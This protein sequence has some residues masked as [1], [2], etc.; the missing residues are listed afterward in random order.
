MFDCLSNFPNLPLVR[1]EAIHMSWSVTSSSGNK[2]PCQVLV[3]YTY[4]YITVLNINT[5]FTK[6][7]NNK[8]E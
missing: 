1:D 2:S 4:I 7:T 8:Q 5:A 3:D 6:F